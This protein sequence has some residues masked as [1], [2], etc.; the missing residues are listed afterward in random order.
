MHYTTAPGKSYVV[1][2]DEKLDYSMANRNPKKFSKQVVDQVLTKHS[3]KESP[4]GRIV[5]IV[6][7]KSKREHNKILG[8]VLSKITAAYKDKLSRAEIDLLL[9][10]ND[11]KLLVE[12]LVS[13]REI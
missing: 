6:T 11:L 10:S 13:M 3:V 1:E 12:G 7:H 4:S 8:L 9:D 2:S 5:D